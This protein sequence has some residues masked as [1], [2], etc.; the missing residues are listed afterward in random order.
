MEFNINDIV[1]QNENNELFFY[2]IANKTRY[3]YICHKIKKTSNIKLD[4]NERLYREVNIKF[5][6]DENILE[7]RWLELDNIKKCKRYY[8]KNIHK[9]NIEL[10]D[11]NKIYIEKI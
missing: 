1:I 10:Y 11:F 9:Y 3:Y 6:Q 5:H 7:F 4:I 8:I 2:V